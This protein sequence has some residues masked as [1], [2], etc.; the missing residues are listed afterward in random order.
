[1]AQEQEL[2]AKVERVQQYVK[3]RQAGA[4]HAETMHAV[5]Q[6]SAKS[7]QEELRRVTADR[8][9]LQRLVLDAEDRAR[10]SA[11]RYESRLEEEQR[12]L[13]EAR[14]RLAATEK[15]NR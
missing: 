2:L 11:T 4:L 15:E 14:E 10:A 9:R 1:M 8:D 13:A 12:E 7:A 6:Q 5:A 3:E